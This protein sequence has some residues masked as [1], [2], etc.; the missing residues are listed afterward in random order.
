M[1]CKRESTRFVNSLKF[2]LKYA[3]LRYVLYR[4]FLRI[5]I[6]KKNRDEFIKTKGIS[7]FDFLPERP[8]Y[9]NGI[10][11]IPRKGSSDYYMFFLERELDIERYLE[12]KDGE[13]FVD[14]G[15]NIGSYAL[16]MSKKYSNNK[17]IA[18]EAHPDNY[19]ALQR[20]IKL[21][22]IDNITAINKAVADRQGSIKMYERYHSGIR[23]GSD[24][25]SISDSFI[26][27]SNVLKTD[28][29]VIEVECDTLDSILS[30]QKENVVLKIDIEGAETMALQGAKSILQR[31]RRI[32]VEIHG[33]N[34]EP[35][36]QILEDFNFEIE[37]TRA[38]MNHVIGT[39]KL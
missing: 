36:L 28:G 11:I 30:L 5:R 19:T 34:L 12:L 2:F 37:E 24:L 22:K 31:V 16:N 14:V 13:T 7:E 23:L 9:K 20:N 15:A 38:E 10:S 21:N 8:Y 39:K 6:G 29:K 26:H 25:Y 17:I 1:I 27:P 35:V 4:I 32:I 33:N 3:R 18:I